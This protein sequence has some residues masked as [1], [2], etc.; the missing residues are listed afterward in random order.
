MIIYHKP[1][2]VLS[3]LKI[4]VTFRCP[5]SCIHCSSDGSPTSTLEIEYHK[6]IDILKQASQMGIREIS[7][8]GG[9]PLVWDG[10]ENA[11]HFCSSN[12][13]KS[14]VYSSGNIKN[15]L[16]VA[17]R[18]KERNLDKIIFSVYSHNSETHDLITRIK[19]SHN[20]TLQAISITNKLGIDVE[21]HFVPLSIN[22]KD[23]EQIA[24]FSRD[25]NVKKISVLRFVPQGRGAAIT[26]KVL[27][28]LQN[29]ELKKIITRLR[30]LGYDIRTGSPYN[31]LMLNDQPRCASGI[32]KMIIG[33]DLS[34]HPCDAFKQISGE[35]ILGRNR[36]SNLS[37]DS[38]ADVWHKSDYLNGIREY[39][40]TDFAV[41]CSKCGNLEK[42]LSG[43]LAQKVLST[44]ELAKI[45]DP[46][47]IKS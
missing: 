26:S 17:S 24:P 5:L 16:N 41:K 40:T 45:P 33:P 19:G 44:G 30:S 42:C 38:L 15:F 11:V 2:F 47:C 6:C 12:N 23:L 10:I 22:Y 29:L 27:T 34:I 25:L 18:L 8:T 46:M 14:V 43:C 39:L 9:E 37:D 32:D 35:E 3:D 21:I 36:H 20:N 28:K 31:F 1:P 13:I 7:F 4:E